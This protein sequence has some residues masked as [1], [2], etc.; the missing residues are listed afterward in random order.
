MISLDLKPEK[1]SSS[2]L[3]LTSSKDE[4][5]IDFSKLLKGMKVGKK[6]THIIQ[7]GALVL[8]LDSADKDAKV[9]KGATKND[10]LLSLLKNDELKS[11]QVKEPLEINPKLTSLLSVKELKTLVS[12]AKNYLKAKI[13]KSDDYKQLQIKELPKTLKGLALLAKKIGVDVSKITLQEIQPE[14]KTKN[15]DVELKK[16][17]VVIKEELKTKKDIPHAKEAK[18][19]TLQDVETTKIVKQEI[20]VQENPRAEKKIELPK[21]IKNTPIFKPQILAEHTTQQ[22]VEVKQ[23]KVEHKT[24]KDRAN[25]TLKLLLRGE[26]PSAETQD[27]TADFSVQSAK[28]IAPKVTTESSKELESLL[29]DKNSTNQSDGVDS[30][31][32]ELLTVHKADSFEVK[33][34]EAKQ[35]IKYLSQD[36]KMAI[37]DYKSPFTRVRVQLNPQRL[38]EIDLTVVQRGK[39]LHVNLTSNSTAIN[40]LSMN[41]TELRTQLN[42]S[43]INNA[44]LN[45]SSGSQ[46][47]ES[48][49]S[50]QHHQNEKQ[51]DEEYNYLQNEEANEEL[52]SSLEIVIPRY[53]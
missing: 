23:F 40:T 53:I 18:T 15:N 43:G 1:T 9:L 25:E 10:T 51:A 20:K 12:N 48:N 26:K 37:E 24:P 21:E 52:L 11:E 17:F 33:L 50:G 34:N 38:G 44:T 45:F 19:L 22:L 28:V 31:K 32:N 35:M 29:H 41:A 42:N 16:D 2:P 47:S 46:N 13:L 5:T 36:V 8:S 49:S 39:N 3:S 27:L 7:N 30:S 6:G 14:V 4:P